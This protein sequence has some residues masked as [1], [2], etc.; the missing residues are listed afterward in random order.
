M[1]PFEV[2]PRTTRSILED[3]CVRGPKMDLASVTTCPTRRGPSEAPIAALAASLLLVDPGGKGGFP[4]G[5][6]AF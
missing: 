1:A 5:A 6:L 4:V 3:W 2:R